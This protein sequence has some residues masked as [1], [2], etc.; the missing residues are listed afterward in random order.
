MRLVCPSCDAEYEIARSAIP[1][2]GR[3]VECSNCG[4]TWFQ[5]FA[6][7]RLGEAV[8][9]A[10][11]D[12]ADPP[13]PTD[14]AVLEVLRQ[15]AA[16][17]VEARQAEAGRSSGLQMQT[18][19]PLTPR[20][21]GADHLQALDAAGDSPAAAPAPRLRRDLLPAIDDVSAALGETPDLGPEW[22]TPPDPRQIKPTL[23]ERAV[24]LLALVGVI[25][26]AL[27]VFAPEIAAKVP[28]FAKASADYVAAVDMT[29]EW[30][31]N[32]LDQAVAWLQALAR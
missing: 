20:E 28:A 24:L 10:D 21:A 25:L 5:A 14:D 4:H 30:G 26:L 17:E 32:H 12:T 1:R 2:S 13:R 16:R 6:D 22:Q 15:E 7:L 9:E 29:I 11:D 19:M 18:E 31:K 27:Y 8:N 23:L 3:E